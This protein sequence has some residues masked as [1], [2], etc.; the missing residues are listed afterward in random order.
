MIIFQILLIVFLSPK[1]YGLLPSTLPAI[2]TRIISCASSASSSASLWSHAEEQQ[3]Q[4]FI[5]VSGGKRH[6]EI[7]E[8]KFGR[9]LVATK[10]LKPN[11]EVLRIPLSCI[12]MQTTD[13][14]NNN[15]Y[16]AGRLAAK[17]LATKQQN[18]D[19]PYISC[20]P[21][22]PSI[23]SRDW[24]L[25]ILE[26]FQNPDWLRDV[27]LAQEWRYNQWSN[28]Q[29]TTNH[30]YDVSN[31]IVLEE[32]NF[33]FSSASLSFKDNEDDRPVFLDCLDLVCSRTIRTGRTLQLVPFLDMANHASREE[34]GGYYKKGNDD[35]IGL[36]AG[37]RG[38]SKGGEVTLDYG[39]RSNEDWL[40]HY[41]FLPNRNLVETVEL[42]KNRIISWDDVGTANEALKQDCRILLDA[43]ET[44]LQ[45]DQLLLR[46]FH[47][48]VPASEDFRYTLAL[49]YRIARKILLSAVAG[50]KTASTASFTSAFGLVDAN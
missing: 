16:W 21:E 23:P 26:E 9:G 38:I 50:Q 10:D 41:G 35:F 15:D 43:F 46:D 11:E 24:P 13:D 49:Q 29:Q 1:C 8:T 18:D 37:E 32:D 25:T 2:Q 48:K 42:G 7:A 12:T 3:L 20:L 36:Y 34:G 31:D 30:P 45:E 27:C 14:D 33:L 39:R 19:C 22:P 6:C 17:L 47:E 40:L 28:Y 5:D 4:E 44:T